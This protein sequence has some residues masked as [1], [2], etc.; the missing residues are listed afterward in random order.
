MLGL[1]LGLH[2]FGLD[3]G[4]A[5]LAGDCFGETPSN[6]VDPALLKGPN[7][8]PGPTGGAVLGLWG[9]FG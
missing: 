1:F 7:L 5:R 2:Q 9:H 6:P 8:S 4:M 3:D